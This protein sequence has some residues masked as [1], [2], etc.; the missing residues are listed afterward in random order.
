MDTTLKE[1][2]PESLRERSAATL[3]LANL[4]RPPCLRQWE[5]LHEAAPQRAWQILAE[6]SSEEIC[7]DLPLPKSADAYEQEFLAT[8]EVGLP[9]PLCPL[10]ESHWNQ[11]QPVP[12]VL[13]ENLLFYR[14]FGLRLRKD[15]IETPDHL[16]HQTEFLAHLYR[17]EALALETGDAER[18]GQFAQ[19][20]RDFLSRHLGRWIPLAAR[21][22]SSEIEDAWPAEWLKLAALVV[23]GLR[24]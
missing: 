6:R 13:H 14:T 16:R 3:F 19:G 11:S 22:L 18:A 4:F 10:N 12:K 24:R 1:V 20:G 5:W 9:Q 2:S 15:C 8:F 17:S 21:H 7:P 23:E